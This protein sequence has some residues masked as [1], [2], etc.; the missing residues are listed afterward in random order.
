MLPRLFEIFTQVDQ[1]LE[2]S[3][4]GLGIG[5]SL[6]KALVELH[7]GRVEARSEGL[8]KGAEFVVVL[9]TAKGAP[10]ARPTPTSRLDDSATS[11]TSKPRRRILIVDDN[12]DGADT[13]A[14][15][16]E[17]LGNDT[18]AVYDGAEAVEVAETY[19]PSMVLLDL[20][21]PR[22]NGFEACEHLRRREWCKG[23]VIVAVTGWG[24]EQFRRRSEEAGFDHHMVKPVDPIELMKLLEQASPR[25]DGAELPG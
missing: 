12:R 19:R 15:V 7:G 21:L 24:Q 3:Q 20:G 10:H 5:L 8:G 14:R 25:V 22:L 9:P 13:L 16:L 17:M 4:G 18:R 2:R 6:V 1:S 23:V 11:A